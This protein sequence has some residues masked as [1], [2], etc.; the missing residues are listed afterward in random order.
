[1][2]L[3]VNALIDASEPRSLIF[4]AVELA[5]LTAHLR[6]CGVECPD[7]GEAATAA[8]T[9]RL[10]LRVRPWRDTG[11]E[12]TRAIVDRCCDG[13]ALVVS[14]DA[15]HAPGFIVAPV[16]ALATRE[17]SAL[18]VFRGAWPHIV[19]FNGGGLWSSLAGGH[20]GVYHAPGSAL[21]SDADDVHDGFWLVECTDGAAYRVAAG[22]GAH[23]AHAAAGDV[24]LY[25][26]RTP[27]RITLVRAP[28]EEVARAVEA[29]TG[30]P[31]HSLGEVAERVANAANI[32]L[33]CGY[34][35]RVV[36]FGY[37]GDVQVRAYGLKARLAAAAA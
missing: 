37:L 3:F 2:T 6:W 13:A 31:A 17:C 32:V 20:G 4:T 34:D 1:M 11:S 22:T 29:R 9:G 16:I 30:A 10:W 15:P 8:Q 7:D 19:D 24:A 25:T 26:G 35:W 23:T 5:E 12:T 28:A 27:S 14:A 36:Q 33:L 21:T 18:E